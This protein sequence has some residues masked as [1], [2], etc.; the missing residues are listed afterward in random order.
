MSHLRGFV[1]RNQFSQRALWLL[2]DK[3]TWMRVL[4]HS[5]KKC[6]FNRCW[7]GLCDIRE[8]RVSPRLSVVNLLTYHPSKQLINHPPPESRL[9]VDV[10]RLNWSGKC[11]RAGRAAIGYPVCP[12]LRRL[13]CLGPALCNRRQTQQSIFKHLHRPP[14]LSSAPLDQAI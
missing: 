10:K 7:D 13:F 2:S 1:Y 14:V 5:S 6:F 12:R 3:L 9:R 8:G 4:F 11:S